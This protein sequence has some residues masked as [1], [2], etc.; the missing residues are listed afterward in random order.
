[1]ALALVGVSALFCLWA[2]LCF[3]FWI[4]SWQ[5]L[6]H[7]TSIMAHTPADTGLTFDAI[8]LGATESG[9]AQLHGWWIPGPPES[10]LTAIYLHG[11]NGN[12]GD[13][14]DA[15][16]PLHAARLN[17]L[18]FDYR[19]Y[20]K[21][22]F[23][24][25]SEQHWRDDAESA[26]TYLRDTRHI[27]A[28]SIVLV[29]N[30][31]GANLALEVAAQHPELAGVVAEN[32]EESPAQA[33]FGDPRAR[34]V[35]ARLLFRDRWD[36]LPSASKLHIPLLW[37][38]K[39][40]G[41]TQASRKPNKVYEAVPSRKTRVWLTDGSDRMKNYGEAVARWVDDLSPGRNSQ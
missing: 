22:R 27:P 32:P 37:F 6:Y 13:R 23:V 12:M 24:R 30:Q 34:L 33:V 21:S 41:Q 5:L 9:Q 38:D 15:L 20:G 10:R 36:S 35:P 4:G 14:V 39:A 17:L 11:A 18:V 31:L 1:M 29:G 25:P 8:E 2:V 26:I 28:A 3:G 7:P 16:A 40:A 19:G